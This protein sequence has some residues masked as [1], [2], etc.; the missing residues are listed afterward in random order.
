MMKSCWIVLLS[1]FTIALSA[2]SS[3]TV[4]DRGQVMV[5]LQNLS[6]TDPIWAGLNLLASKGI[7]SRRNSTISVNGRSYTITYVDST[8]LYY[9]ER[10]DGTT[11]EGQ[12][13]V[14]FI[15][16]LFATT[17]YQIITGS[18]YQ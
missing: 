6:S 9:L 8:K 15:R 11:T 5:V 17:E 1:M 10:P 7:Q 14:A 18:S 16:D 12:R 13:T 3:M 2:Q 4:D